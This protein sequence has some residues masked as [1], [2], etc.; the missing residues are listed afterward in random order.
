MRVL[1]TGG[2]GFVGSHVVA[3]L[4]GRG[5]EVLVVDDMSTGK[6]SNL[7]GDVLVEELDIGDPTLPGV[8]SSFRPEVIAHC[9][10]QA[11]VTVSMDNPLL[12]VQTNVVGGINVGK[13]ATESGCAQFVYVTTGGALYGSPDYLPCDEDHPVR[14]VSAYGLSKWTLEQYLRILLPASMQLKV[15]RLANVYGP[16][17]DPH[18]EAGVVAIFGGRMLR[19][20][21]VTIFGDG[22]QTR[23]FVY[24]DDVARAYELAQIASEPVT[25]NIGSGAGITVN[26]LFRRMADQAGF[27]LSPVHQEERPGDIRHVV[28]D[29]SRARRLLG[30]APKA[31]LDEGLRETLAWL[32]AGT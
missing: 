1:V 27:T 24:V 22:E 10:A 29:N 17:Q 20:E 14:P 12:D 3:R 2:A 4:L 8:M 23:D 25:V 5:D 16:R 30:W 9:A 31:S 28:L 13:A 18:G 15:L 19:G 11:S 6:H 32:G 21:Q 26:E 7:P